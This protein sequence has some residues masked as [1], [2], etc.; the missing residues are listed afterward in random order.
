MNG[1][2]VLQIVLQMMTA[3]VDAVRLWWFTAGG[4]ALILI[5]TAGY[6]LLDGRTI[7]QDGVWTKPM[8]FQERSI[9]FDRCLATS[10][11]SSRSVPEV[12]VMEAMR[13]QPRYPSSRFDHSVGDACRFVR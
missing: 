7:G 12:S 9:S 8:K 13:D 6:A 11:A 5:C 4:L 2:S 3:P 10:W 1:G